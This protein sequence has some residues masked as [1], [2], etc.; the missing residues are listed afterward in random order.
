MAEGPCQRGFFDVLGNAEEWEI[1]YGDL[2][3]FN[4]RRTYPKGLDAKTKRAIRLVL[5]LS[6]ARLSTPIPQVVTKTIEE[7]G[8]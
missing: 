2:Q 7:E 1:S 3:I 6:D 8:S 4:S 5:D